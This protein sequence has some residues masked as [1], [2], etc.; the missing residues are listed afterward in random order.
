MEIE[1]I[2]KIKCPV[3]GGNVEVVDSYT[4]LNG[5]GIYKDE[6]RHDE[7]GNHCLSV[8]RPFNEGNKTQY[9]CKKCG[10]YFETKHIKDSVESFKA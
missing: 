3:C 6:I 7:N 2:S 10:R 9:H 8:F 5:S 4:V 1:G